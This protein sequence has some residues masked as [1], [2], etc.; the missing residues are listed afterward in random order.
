MANRPCRLTAN[1]IPVNGMS[2]V[3]EQK[4][5]EA[6]AAFQ[7]RDLG[8]TER[9]CAGILREAPQHPVALRLLGMV[10]LAG[11]NAADAVS[12]MSRAAQSGPDDPTL[13]EALG[14]AHLVLQDNPSA[15]AAFRRAFGLGADHASLHMRFGLALG[16]Q[17]KL[18][19]AVVSLSTAA[20]MS[21]DVPDVHL[22]LGNA[23]AQQNRP[24][25]ALASYR[26]ALTLQPRHADAHFNIGT[27]LR[28]IGRNDE[29]LAAYQTV[30][31]LAP[32]RADAHHNIGTM[33]QSQ[34][35]LQEAAACYRKVLALDPQHV[36]SLNTMGNV[37]REQGQR[38]EA[39]ALYAKALAARPD[40]ADAYINLGTLRAEEH[41]Y[42]EARALYE[43]AA[44]LDPRSFEAHHNLGGLFLAQAQP[45]DAIACYRR[46]LEC[47]SS[48]AFI[49][50][51]LSG[52][53]RT[54]G[55]L[56]AAA[57]CAR[58]ALELDA[59]HAAACYSLAETLK[60]QDRLDEAVA[61][62]ERA[63]ARKP[64]HVAALNSLVHV[65]QH[66]CSWG[67][68]EEQWGR[69]SGA[70]AAGGKGAVSPF[71]L[72][73]VTTSAAEQLACARAWAEQ[74]VLPLA[75]AR[76]GL[77]FDFSGRRRRDQLRIGY[78]SWGFHRHAT[79]YWAAQLFELHDRR[80]Y[81]VYAYDY[82][83]D[84]RSEIRARI[85]KGVDRFVH[86]EP[87]S[88]L[89]TA[90]R[91]YA[92]QVDVLV[93]LTGYTLGSRPQIVALKPAPV[94]VNWFYPGTMGTDL[95]DYFIADPFV[96]PP[97]AERF[98]AE[99]ISRMPDCYMITDRLREVSGRVPARSECG[100]PEN[101]VVFCCFN[102]AY[103]ILPE[104]FGAWM[105]IM[106]AV[107]G[108]V[109]WLAEANRW[110]SGNLRRE[111]AA[112][113]VDAARLV[114]APR[115]PL[116]EYMVQYRIADFAL[117][118][119]PYTSHTTASDALWMGCPLAAC[120][121]ETFASRVSGSVL[122]SAGMG[123]LVTDNLRDYERLVISLA[124][125]PGK[126][127]DL[128]RRLDRTRDSHPLFDTPRFVTNL[129]R[130]YDAM[131][132]AYLEA[133][134]GLMRPARSGAVSGAGE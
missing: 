31:A 97:G 132:H 102:Q 103:K 129:E 56:E 40:H 29:A 26:R 49:H 54:A 131:F 18:D 30:L 123:D 76:A 111:A 125:A 96:V 25:E 68:L 41:R 121:G 88:T 39:A 20:R 105:R 130:A 19:E 37:L 7:A 107:P 21:P 35:R 86:A 78:L 98:F 127:S 74:H 124:T 77:G 24:E 113:G 99:K 55:D 95:M 62:Y 3:Q 108:S 66:L 112:R 94:Q 22:S 64:D 50:V 110:Q 126:L 4:V 119:F 60:L 106:Q 70:I 14:L 118:T 58:K 8:G 63:L 117:D 134:R 109:L 73:S 101:S 34:G 83:P 59:D 89:D 5:Q 69:L 48:Q 38:D 120:A 17:G 80:R 116:G 90:R 57:A 47:D 23:L 91:I 9:A 2:S 114:F 71:S 45:R 75:A 61:W 46:A 1:R 11:G 79:S 122:I 115:Q 128:R 133:P 33:Y 84:D 16:A 28:R 32:D 53:Y 52:A 6:L 67:G 10:R 87:E 81:E 65:R 92:D 43:K 100:L 104:M 93:D 82:G 72:A 36:A 13:L 15:E 51:S 85:R 12:L 44:S 27:L 42:A